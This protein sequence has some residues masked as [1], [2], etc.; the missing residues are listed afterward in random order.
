MKP[1]EITEEKPKTTKNLDKNDFLKRIKSIK[2]EDLIGIIGMTIALATA[3]ILII[4][5]FM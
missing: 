5:V 1:N 2:S 4:G 3:F